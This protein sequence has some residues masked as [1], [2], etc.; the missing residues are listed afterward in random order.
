MATVRYTFTLDAVKD[1]GVV[2]WLDSQPNT[3]AA[4]REALKAYVGKPTNAEL[5]AKLDEVLNAIQTARLVT[6]SPA[7]P[8]ASQGGEPAAAVEGFS[9]MLKRF[10]GT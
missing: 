4:I 8:E 7:Q 6:S 2:R 3:S 9:K 1:A 10:S 5:G